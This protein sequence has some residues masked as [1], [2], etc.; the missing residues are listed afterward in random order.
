MTQAGSRNNKHRGASDE[1][2]VAR[3]LGGKRH[4]A[5]TGGP[6]DVQHNSFA[7]QVK[8]GKAVV[9]Q[10]MRDALA[11]ARAAAVGTAK[12]P[13]VVLIDRRGTRLQR[14]ICFALEEFAAEHGYG[15]EATE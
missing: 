11:S 1:R 13:A 8:G 9:T 6:E 5:D 7:I 10:P 15:Q 12:L 3:I 4:L 14:W 2:D